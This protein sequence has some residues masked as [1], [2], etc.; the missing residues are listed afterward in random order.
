MAPKRKEGYEAATVR[1]ILAPVRGMYNQAIEDGEPIPL[2]PEARFGKK[3]R[4]GAKNQNQSAFERETSIFLQKTLQL[5]P[6][7]SALSL[8][9]ANWN[10]ARR[11][12]RAES[13]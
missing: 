11:I 13:F 8:R 3:N 5:A 10:T 2:N 6:E 9:F 1:N 4:G 12:D 7:N